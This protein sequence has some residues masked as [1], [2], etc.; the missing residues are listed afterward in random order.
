M[1]IV[2]MITLMTLGHVIVFVFVAHICLCLRMY[3]CLYCFIFDS[4]CIFVFIAHICLCLR[5]Y[6]SSRSSSSSS[7]QWEWLWIR[8]RAWDTGYLHSPDLFFLLKRKLSNL[9]KNVCGTLLLPSNPA[10]HQTEDN[11]RLALVEAICIFWFTLEYLLRLVAV[12]NSTISFGQSQ[13]KL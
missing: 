1:I 13:T 2:L 3:L 8:C 5:L 7:P 9:L 11:P 6:R 4:G 12:P 10:N